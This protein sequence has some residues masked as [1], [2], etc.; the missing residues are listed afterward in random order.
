MIADIILDLKIKDVDKTYSY[1]VPKALEDTVQV[2]MRCFVSFGKI[3]R[4]G[5]IMGLREGFDPSLKEIDE[6]MDKEPVLTKELIDVA[7]YL[8]KTSY[9]PL[10]S[11][12]ET[13]LPSALKV[14][15]KKELIIKTKDNFRLSI[16]FGDKEVVDY[17]SINPSDIPFIKECIEKGEAEIS[18][19]FKRKEFIIKE[20]IITL[21]EEP[22]KKTPLRERIIEYLKSNGGSSLWD[23]IREELLV[24]STTINKMAELGIVSITEREKY[25]DISTLKPLEDKKV[26]LNPA[27]EK[28]FN[29]LKSNLNKNTTYLLRGI[30]G[31]GKTEIYINLIEEVVKQGKDAIL[32]VPEISLTPMMV[33]RFKSRFK[34]NVAIFH[35]ELSNNTKYDEWRKV[36]R[37]EVKIAVGARSAVF[38]PFKNLGIIIIDEEHEQSYKQDNSP[39]YH[40]KDV[41]LKRSELNNSML[42]LGSATPSIEAYARAKKGVYNLLELDVRANAKPLPKTIVVNLNQE[43]KKGMKGYISN[44]LKEEIKKR[45][46][47]HEQTVLL[48]N[49]RGYS[50]YIMCRAC[51][52]TEKCPNCDVSLTYHEYSKKL[53]CHYCNYEK[54]VIDTCGKCGSKY[55][56]KVGYGTEKIE[57]ELKALFPSARV[58]RMDNDTTRGKMG[59][60]KVLYEF[61]TNGDILLGTQMIAKGLDFPNVT[62]VGV[63]NADQ[64]LDIP[65]FRSKENTFSLLTQVSGRA[66][67][68][69]KEGLVVIQTHNENQYAIKNALRQDYLSFYEEEMKVRMIARFI[70]YYNMTVIRVKSKNINDSY[71]KA[72]GIKENLLDLLK[73]EGIIVLGPIP[74]TISKVD[75]YYIFNIIIKYKKVKELD[76]ILKNIYDGNR[77][78]NILISI[79]KFPTSF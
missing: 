50:N 70:P 20:K 49:R 59:H 46:I 65:D 26:E 1:L 77:D 45:L 51:G 31:S 29:E 39:I 13:M 6:L 52:N 60:E 71:T 34:D 27:Q 25:R 79:D 41:A 12:L 14:G 43:F 5:F 18:Y 53:K 64:S 69:E 37:G 48:L 16:L 33:N 11:Y 17:D 22:V 62:L 76:N 78:G 21:V 3:Y 7:L 38:M 10:V 32:L 2:G 57:E 23:N 72:M 9:Y 74:P 15:Y 4:M 54:R 61:E 30:T 58:V 67:R 66:G 42:L 19:N 35:S 24:T 55:L 56:E 40:A 63:L 8:S 36:I 47:N 44:T 28:I 73:E 75:N 68:G